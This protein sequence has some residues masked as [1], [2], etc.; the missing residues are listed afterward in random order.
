MNR[1]IAIITGS[2]AD[3]GLLTPLLRHI[4][5]ERRLQLQ[6]LVTGMHLSHRFGNS[7]EK[8]IADGLAIAARVPIS[9]EEDTP[10]AIARALAEGIT[11]FNQVLSNLNPDLLVVL[12]DRFEILAAVQAAMLCHVPVAHIH[13]GEITEGAMDDAIRH[14]I[15][16]LSHLHF[17]A[18]DDYRRR[19]LQLGEPADRVFNVGALA[20]DLVSSVTLLEQNELEA[21]LGF[22]LATQNFLV[23]YQPVTL[24][25]TAS[26]EGIINLLTALDQFPDAHIIF[27]RANA[28]PGGAQINQAIDQYVAHHPERCAVF[29]VLGSQRYLSAARLADAVIGNSSSGLI[30]IPVLGT[31]TVNIGNRQTGRLRCASVIDTGNDSPAIVAGIEQALSPAFREQCAQQSCPYG[32]GGTASRIVEVLAG[33]PLDSLLC[34]PFNDLPAET[35]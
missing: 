19:I 1:K 26:Q 28:D 9:L 14:S 20:V 15:T 33:H 12:G 35:S 25:E 11:G 7:V 3:Y 17:A 24:D 2:R 10:A 27:T 13:G 22:R 5:E 4:E 23:T 34:K 32:D 18:T 8:I 6:L 16:K 21:A 29:D 31:S 30:E